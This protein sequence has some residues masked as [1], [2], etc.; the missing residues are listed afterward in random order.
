LFWAAA[1]AHWR[2]GDWLPSDLEGRDLGV[3]GVVS[4]LP[5]MT[6]RG[7]RF[8]L[9]VEGADT[10]RLPKTLLLS[11]YGNTSAEEAPVSP[12]AGGAQG[13]G[14]RRDRRRARLHAPCG[15]RRAGAAHL[16]DGDGRGARALV[17]PH[18]V[19]VAHA[20]PRAGGHRA[21]RSVGAARAG[22]VALLRRGAAHL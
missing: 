7:V 3:V 10:A 15:L 14:D 4:A 6:E 8:E 17:R 5:A 12:L 20:R 22:V 19:R 21:V 13:G 2:M 11:W 1:C 18:L 9:E 16:L